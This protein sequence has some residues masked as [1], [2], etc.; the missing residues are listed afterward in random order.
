MTLMRY[1]IIND[2]IVDT[3]TC[4]VKMRLSVPKYETTLQFQCKVL[5]GQLVPKWVDG[6]L[7]WAP[8]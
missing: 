7:T 4:W 8:K 1:K 5:N 3:H 6:T 2:S